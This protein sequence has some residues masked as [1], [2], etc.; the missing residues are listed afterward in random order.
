MNAGS[1]NCRIDVYGKT[2]IENELGEI[3]YTYSKIKSVWAEV[4]PLNGTVKPL[5]GETQY[6][7]ISHKFT[8]R[9]N[10]IPNLSNDMYFMFGG[11][12]YD[13]K[14]FQPNYKHKNSIEIMCGLVIE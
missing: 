5:Q 8:V 4:A 14:Y 3:D 7:E 12:R 13:I 10:S 9:A 6:V 11:Q 2:Q 1:L